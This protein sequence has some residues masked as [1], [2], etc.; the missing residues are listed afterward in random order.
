MGWD[1]WHRTLLLELF[2]KRSYRKSKFNTENISIH[3]INAADIS[4]EQYYWDSIFL[5]KM[6]SVNYVR[7]IGVIFHTSQ[8]SPIQSTAGITNSWFKPT[9]I[10][11]R[12]LSK[13]FLCRNPG[14][15]RP[16]LLMFH[17]LFKNGICISS[18]GKNISHFAPLFF[19]W[20]QQLWGLIV[21]TTRTYLCRY[22]GKVWSSEVHQM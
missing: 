22:L 11:E 13:F 21:Y 20:A 9:E 7:H 12:I 16:L 1:F 8:T 10:R 6:Y 3:C 17:A 2:W 4:R 15:L 19:T 14:L 18:A 5:Q